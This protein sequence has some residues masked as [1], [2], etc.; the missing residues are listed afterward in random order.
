VSHNVAIVVRSPSNAGLAEE[1]PLAYQDVAAVVDVLARAE[2]ATP[3]GRRRP[4]GVVKG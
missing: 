3:V 2:L 1:A 4:T